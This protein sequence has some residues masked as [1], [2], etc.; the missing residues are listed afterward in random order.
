MTKNTLMLV[1]LA[2]TSAA[3]TPCA[4]QIY[5]WRDSAGKTVISDTPPP[6]TIK[7]TVRNSGGVPLAQGSERAVEKPA[8]APKTTAEKDMEFKKRQ[9]EARE[10]TEKDEKEAKANRDRLENCDRARRSLAALES[11]RQVSTLDASGNPQ[12]MDTAQRSAELERTRA[13]V[14]EACR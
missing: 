4:A 14:G 2:L 6:G 11:G 3:M 12:V 10:K 1:A 9:Q 8:D 7:S 5:Q 13:F